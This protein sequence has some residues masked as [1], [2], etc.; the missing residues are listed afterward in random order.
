MEKMIAAIYLATHA[1]YQQYCWSKP[2]LK[3]AN[4]NLSEDNLILCKHIHQNVSKHFCGN[5]IS[6]CMCP[7]KR[8][9]F[10][11]IAEMFVVSVFNSNL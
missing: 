4:E 9:L 3:L 11:H 6:I 5:Q 7:P 10:A 2:P 1:Q 8:K